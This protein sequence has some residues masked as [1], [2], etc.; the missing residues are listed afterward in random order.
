MAALSALMATAAVVAAGTSLANGYAQQQAA[1]GNAAAQ[2]GTAD[3][4]ARLSTV[5]A[6]DAIARGE[7]DAAKIKAN[8]RRIT[9][10]QRAAMAAQGLDPDVGSGLDLQTDTAVLSSADAA[11]VRNNAWREAWGYRVEAVNATAAGRYAEISGNA[12]ARASILTGSLEATR[13]GLQ[14]GYYAKG[15]K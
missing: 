12:A 15:G 13:Y 3:V 10:S 4:N 2:K 14:A 11:T 7:K 8:A 6:D 9:G 5:A 1:L